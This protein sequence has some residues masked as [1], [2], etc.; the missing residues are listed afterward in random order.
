MIPIAH[1][2][3]KSSP[4]SRQDQAS[5]LSTRACNPGVQWPGRGDELTRAPLFV[6][7]LGQI[8]AGGPILADQAVEADV[9]VAA[10]TRR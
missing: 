8:A 6:P 9:P 1:G 2:R 3:W 4:H 7:V 10:G 5:I